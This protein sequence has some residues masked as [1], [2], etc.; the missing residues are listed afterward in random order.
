[1]IKKK[2]NIIVNF[3]MQHSVKVVL[4]GVIKKLVLHD[5]ATEN[6]R[7]LRQENEVFVPIT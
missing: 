4:L 3:E 7:V 1:M 6:W 2:R 5:Y